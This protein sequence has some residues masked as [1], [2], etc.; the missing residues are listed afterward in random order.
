VLR[1]SERSSSNLA[2]ENLQ[3]LSLTNRFLPIYCS[4]VDVDFGRPDPDPLV[5]GTDPDP[6][7]DLS[8]SGNP[9]GWKYVKRAVVYV[10]VIPLPPVLKSL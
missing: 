3:L 2:A 1:R 5:R 7:K 4:V 9:T 8:V 6:R 10:S